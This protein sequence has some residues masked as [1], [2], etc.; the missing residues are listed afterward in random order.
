MPTVDG[1]SLIGWGVVRE[2]PWHFVGLFETQI[3]T[4]AKAIDMGAGYSARYGESTDGEN[5]AWS[6]DN[7]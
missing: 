7:A 5:F 6:D 3:E 2:E 4:A 1:K